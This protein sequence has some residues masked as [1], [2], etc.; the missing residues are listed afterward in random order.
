MTTRNPPPPP[1][2]QLGDPPDPTPSPAHGLLGARGDA[3]VARSKREDREKLLQL[4]IVAAHQLKSPLTSI[5]T[6]L[7]LLLGG[8]VGPVSTTQ[9]DLL[10][11]ANASCAR[12]TNVVADLLRLRQLDV[13][14]REDLTP[15]DVAAAFRT[16]VDRVREAAS[17]KELELVESSELSD[18]E[19]AWTVADRATLGEVL[20]VLLEN[21]V[22]YTPRGGRIL[23]RLYEQE[24]PG[25]AEGDPSEW[26]LAFE[27]VDTGIGIPPEALK[28]L[29]SE[30]YRAPNAKVMSQEGTGLGLAF[31]RQ[32]VRVFGGSLEVGPAETGGVR[33]VATFPL[34]APDANAAEGASASSS[35]PER[36]PS[37]RVVIIGGVT[38]GSKAAA[39]IMR[40]DPDAQVTVVERGR[41]LAYAGC[42]LPYYVSG[43]VRDQMGLLSSP[44]GDVR[45]S[46][47]F[48][49]LKNVRTMDLSEAVAIDRAEHQ[50][51]VRKLVDGSQTVLPYDKLVLATGARAAIPAIENVRMKGIFTLHGVDDAE[52][53]RAELMSSSAKDVLIVG[54]GLLGVQITEA[55][56]VR[57]SRITLVEAAPHILGIIDPELSLLLRRYL[58][59]RGVKVIPDAPVVGFE[60]GGRVRAAVL[61]DGRRLWC[62][63]AV[64]ATG[65]APNVTLAEHAD[66]EIGTTGAIRVDATLRTSDPDIYA[67]GDCAETTHLLTGR[68]TLAPT[69][70]KAVKQGRA[71]A[72]NVCGGHEEFPGVVGSMI[73]RIFDWNIGTTGLTETEAREAGFD[74]V[75]ALVPTPD[76]EHFL[77]TAQPMILKVVADRQT[78]R[79]LGAQ[80]IGPGN[81]DKR[82]DVVAM[83]LTSGLDLERF[84]QLD[85]GYAPHFSLALDGVIA[86]VNVLRNKLDGVFRGITGRELKDLLDRG[87]APV[88]LDVRLPAEFSRQRLAGS[89]HIPLGSLR[90][91]LH[92]V[93]RNRPIVTIE[94]IGVRAYEAAL[95][96]QHAGHTDVRVLDGG[97]DAW[98][99]DLE[100]L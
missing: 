54:A 88:L 93:P 34:R 57:G 46:S 96:L 63:F 68:P 24:Q 8:F 82:I 70:S 12:G 5:Q 52:A 35:G 1:L 25:P 45:D 32:A 80:G 16:A 38:G 2:A 94:K 7:S 26:F 27:V 99:Y 33:A 61:A 97:L 37:R 15:V 67:V 23:T 75:C 22:K 20:H 40:L 9:K 53:I 78:R 17:Q 51:T 85:L 60:G 79:L 31:A 77:P 65:V 6:I 56:A 21:A 71:V 3:E 81:V 41:V 58:E 48:H 91:R 11:R 76:R 62:D 28:N 10:E 89:L 95:I 39:K 4:A 49:N 59:S 73:I 42:G 44:L 69:G 64:L 72:I 19:A 55:V 43:V 74:P 36:Q 83:A 30:F 90:G 100:R 18:R 13:L 86:A 29:F 87:E 47:F 84:S 50:V 14:S 92:E 98:P 66:L